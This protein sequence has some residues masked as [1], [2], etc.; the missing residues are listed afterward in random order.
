MIF[1]IFGIALFAGIIYFSDQLFSSSFSF[2]IIILGI[3]LSLIFIIFGSCQI[4]DTINLGSRKIAAF[5]QRQ[6]YADLATLNES[7]TSS[8]Y[9][10]T[11]VFLYEQIINFNKEVRKA[12]S[13][14][15][16]W[17]GI[18]FDSAY[19]DLDTIPISILVN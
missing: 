19:R 3:I 9:V 14:S 12:N 6:V 17:R 1:L 13:H 15:N 16:F 4:G 5:Q 2:F 10:N 18:L 11:A 8:Q 7:S